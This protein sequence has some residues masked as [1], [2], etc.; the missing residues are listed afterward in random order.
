MWPSGEEL[1]TRRASTWCPARPCPTWSWPSVG[2]DGKVSI[3]NN[4]GSTD[5][6]VDVLGCFDGDADGRYVALSP[7]RVLDTRDGT[8]APLAQVGQ[9]PLP[10]TSA[11]SGRRAVRGVSGVMLNVTAVAPTGNTFVTVYPSGT[12]RPLGLEPQRRPPARSI[13]NMV[14][15]RIGADGTVL[16]YNNAGN[17]DLVA[18]VVGYF[19]A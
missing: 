1:P 18:D 8:G 14:L 11:G 17:V 9:T 2:A 6:V 16:M 10:V 15:A 13:P 12:D 7:S 4:T 5:V 3:Y 19:T